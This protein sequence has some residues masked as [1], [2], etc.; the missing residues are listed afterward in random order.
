LLPG[1]PVLDVTDGWVS[2]ARPK[3]GMARTTLTYPTLD[4]ARLIVVV[5]AGAE[6]A[7]AVRGVLAGDRSM[8]AAHLTAP[9]IR[10]YLDAAAASRL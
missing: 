5:V 8:P 4:A 2:F 1:D 10:F 3:G 9:N 6:K 7:E